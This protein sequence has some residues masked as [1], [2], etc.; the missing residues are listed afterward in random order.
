M[1]RTTDV[2]VGGIIEVDAAIDI[3]PFIETANVLVTDLCA[4]AVDEDGVLVYSSVRL[5]LIERWL[6][7]HFYATR[8]PR[9]V[10]E[11]A[12]PVA[13]ENQSKVGLGFNNSHYG[14]MA[15]RL[16]TEGGL[17]RLDYSVG[18]GGLPRAGVTWLGTELTVSDGVEE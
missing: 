9:A 8:D 16:D 3:D 15:M 13:Q 7:A 4:T 17:A 14:Q 12:G 5:E 6:S 10:Y 1:P 11:K 2:L 18:K